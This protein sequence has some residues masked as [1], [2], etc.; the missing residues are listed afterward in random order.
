MA[1]CGAWP[2]SSTTW[3]TSWTRE[4][5]FVLLPAAVPACN[6]IYQSVHHQPCSLTC[7]S[8]AVPLMCRAVDENLALRASLRQLDELYATTELG[9][10]GGGGARPGGGGYGAGSY[11]GGGA[12][13]AGLGLPYHAYTSGSQG[14]PGG[15][16]GTG[17]GVMGSPG[18]GPGAGGYMSASYSPG[19]GVA[20]SPMR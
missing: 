2:S 14:Q 15:Q 8:T 13:G 11:Q 18:V 16:Q 3:A 9:C 1:Y 7:M 12:G 10:G 4:C 6:L 20:Y 17:S 5:V 19:G